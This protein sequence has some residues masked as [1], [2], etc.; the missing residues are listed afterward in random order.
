V[1]LLATQEHPWAILPGLLP[2]VSQAVV[3]TMSGKLA[4]DSLLAALTGGRDARASEPK[5]G[6]IAILGLY[7][8]IVP[9]AGSMAEYLGGT[10]AERFTAR[11]RELV[12]DSS[13]SAI[14]VDTYSPGGDVTGVEEASRALFDARGSKPIVAIAN[15]TMASAAYWIASAAGEISVTPSA[16][17]G[18]IGVY[19]VH[20]DVSRAA[21]MAGVKTTLVSAGERKTDG[22]PYEPLSDEARG[23]MQGRVNDYYAA[24]VGDVARNRGTSSR[25][26]REGFGKGLTFVGAEAVRHGLADRVETLDQLVTRL[27]LK[28]G[29]P[30][31]V[32]ADR[33]QNSNGAA[34]LD[35]D[36]ARR[37]ARARTVADLEARRARTMALAVDDSLRARLMAV[38]VPAES[39]APIVRQRVASTFAACVRS[40]QLRGPI[41]LRWFGGREIRVTQGLHAA[42]FG[43]VWLADDLTPEQ[44]AITCAHELRHAWQHAAFAAGSWQ[45][46][47]NPAARRWLEDDAEAFAV[48]FVQSAC[49]I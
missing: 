26:V 30:R 25:A 24:F 29:A 6:A 7:G 23:Y 39:V 5:R 17:V 28:Y 8:V 47:N 32:S 10:S 48:S 11:L 43:E 3:R 16:E 4:S 27:G 41:T 19:A 44:A 31:S 20:Q 15:H 1:T 49:A 12:R 18:G 13:V 45:L 36:L 34:A 38:E 37:R 21:E 9:R 22:N 14:V 2:I 46:A 33:Q 35:P 40:L 42:A